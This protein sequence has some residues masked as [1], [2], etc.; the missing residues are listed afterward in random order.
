[1]SSLIKYKRRGRRSSASTKSSH[2]CRQRL[3]GMRW[4]SPR[5]TSERSIAS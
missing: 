4:S 2:R 3:M 5:M 1:L